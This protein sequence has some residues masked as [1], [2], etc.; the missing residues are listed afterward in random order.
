MPSD[1]V[2][3][4]HSAWGAQGSPCIPAVPCLT[5]TLLLETPW[6]APELLGVQGAQAEVAPDWPPDW[7]QLL[8]HRHQGL[9]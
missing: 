3:R 1:S 5:I 7:D 6:G 4:Q 9:L 8:H 2:G